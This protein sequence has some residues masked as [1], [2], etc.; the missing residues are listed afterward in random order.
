[1][2]LSFDQEVS[3]TAWG[4]LKPTQVQARDL[5]NKGTTEQ[6]IAPNQEIE[7][8]A[9]YTRR[10]PL[11]FGKE[12]G[13]SALSGAVLH[14]VVLCS[15]LPRSPAS[16]SGLISPRIKGGSC[17]LHL[18]TC[19]FRGTINHHHYQEGGGENLRPLRWTLLGATGEVG[20]KLSRGPGQ[21]CHPI[22]T[23]SPREAT[24]SLSYMFS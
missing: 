12:K 24:S 9:L 3:S 6:K 8:G 10:A 15:T 5:V 2:F 14:L 7:P 17:P 11:P 21:W 22:S 4:E 23:S 1:M 18:S 20:E 13:L 16:L 19:L